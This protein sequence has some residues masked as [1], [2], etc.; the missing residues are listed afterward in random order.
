MQMWHLP[1][2]F[3]PDFLLTFFGN[4]KFMQIHF[5]CSSHFRWY[6]RIYTLVPK[7]K[8]LLPVVSR[9]SGVYREFLGQNNGN[10]DQKINAPLNN[11]T[12][13]QSHTPTVVQG[14]R[15]LMEHPSWVF[16][17]LQYFETILPSLESLWYSLQDEVYFMGGG[18]AWGLWR[19]QTWSSSWSPS[20]ILSRVRNE[21][22]T[23]RIN[24]LL[25][26]TC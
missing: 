2:I 18:S 12:Y 8:L 4:S 25:C 6:W 7:K 5:F 21:V 20:W 11:R 15:G 26:L 1:A 14:G 17:M 24:N 16:D 3:A 9:M 23:V 22:K 13:T 19:H 10:Y